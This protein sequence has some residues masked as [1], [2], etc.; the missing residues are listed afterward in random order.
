MNRT[1]QKKV[2]ET[3]LHLKGH[4]IFSKHRDEK[5]G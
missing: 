5:D 4:A 3:I 1:E 2:E